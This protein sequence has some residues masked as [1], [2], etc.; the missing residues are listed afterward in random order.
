MSSW[1][2]CW[3]V[4]H[5][6]KCRV[7]FAYKSTARVLEAREFRT[8]VVERLFDELLRVL[9]NDP[10]IAL[11]GLDNTAGR[12]T[13]DAVGFKYLVEAGLGSGVNDFRA[14]RMHTFPGP[15]NAQ[16]LWPN[17]AAVCAIPNARAYGDLRSAE[18]ISVVSRC[19]RIKRLV[20]HSLELRSTLVTDAECVTK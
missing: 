8:S 20:H 6:C 17:E 13:L 12:R 9:P 4:F 15:R 18:S 16:T 10:Q 1:Q 3:A 19:W 14:L 2:F 7:T 11:C 5:Q